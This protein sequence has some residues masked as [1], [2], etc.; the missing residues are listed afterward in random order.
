MVEGDVLLMLWWG[1]GW[2]VDP[3]PRF[4]RLQ[5]WRHRSIPMVAEIRTLLFDT[6]YCTTRGSKAQLGFR[7]F[8]MK[9][10]EAG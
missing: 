4:P 7:L 2:S 6:R 3:A 1:L 10:V 8:Y 5:G 9:T